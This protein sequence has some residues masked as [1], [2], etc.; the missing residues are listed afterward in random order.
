MFEPKVKVLWLIKGLGLGGAEALLV[1]HAR[2]AGH[3]HFEY[4]CAV[5][6]DDLDDRV[7][8]LEGQGVAIHQLG[9]GRFGAVAWPV[10]LDRLIR[11]MRPDVVHTHSPL[12]ASI[13]RLTTRTVPKS[14]RPLMVHTEHNRWPSYHPVTRSLNCLTHDLV[15]EHIAVSEEARRTVMPRR[16]QERVRTVFHGID[17]AAVKGAGRDRAVV[18]AELGLD[19][20]DIAVVNVANLRASKDHETLLAAARRVIDERDDVAFFVI[21][22]G[23]LLKELED[24]A[25]ALGIADRVHFMGRRADV[26]R[27]LAG[28]DLM[29]H[30]SSH[31]G[32]PVALMEAQAAEL[33]V[34]ATRAGGVSEIIQDGVTGVLV[35]VGDP[36]ALADGLLLLIRDAEIRR[37]FAVQ[38]G[39]AARDLDAATAVGIYESLYRERAGGRRGEEG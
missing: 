22:D 36:S 2:V 10:R 13:A 25:D 37:S 33:P 9:A 12:P 20:A 30:S 15:D 16:R 34:V 4:H 38:A 23:P 21:G 19:T 7:A 5:V 11:T 27:L 18:R 3:G 14:R 35:D 17:V 28:M 39:V 32:L 24:R 1:E 26:P 6:R 29:A 8:D 31:E